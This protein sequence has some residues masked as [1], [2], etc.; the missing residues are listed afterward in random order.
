[1]SRTLLQQALDALKPM[2]DSRDDTAIQRAITALEAELAKPEQQSISTNNLGGQAV[3]YPVSNL[4]Q[5]IIGWINGE[6]QYGKS[7]QAPSNR[8]WMTKDELAKMYGE[9][10]QEQEPLAWCSLN[11]RGEIGY[12]D[13]KP[14]IMVGKV[15]NDCHETPLYTAPPRKPWQG[16]TDEEM[17]TLTTGTGPITMLPFRETKTFIRAIEAKLKEKN[18]ADSSP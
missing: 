1:M 17:P 5:K 2:K 14:M 10:E 16:L 3:I 12:F 13:G 7:E 11:G 6:P 15:G 18:T 9:Q 4:Q 8:V